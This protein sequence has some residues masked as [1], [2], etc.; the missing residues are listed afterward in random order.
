MAGIALSGL[1][2]GLNTEAIITKLMEVERAPKARLETREGQVKARG[3]MLGEIQ[4]KLQSLSDAAGALR[5]VGV[6]SEVQSVQSSDSTSVSAK[7]LSGTGPGGYQIEVTQLA[8]AEQRTFAF[9]AGEAASQLTINGAT[10]ELGASA[11]LEEAAAAINGNAETDVYAVAS[12]GKLIL[13]SRTTGAANAIAAS[14]ATISEE[15]EKLKVGRDAEYS[16]D[17]VA[18]TSS[19]NVTTEAVPGLELSLKSLTSTP[20]TVTVG[21]PEPNHEEITSKLKAFVSAYNA[22]LDAIRSRVTETRVANPKSQA[23]SN[24]G[25][26]FG[27]SGLNDLLSQMRNF[28]SES[29]LSALGIGTGAPSKN[30]SSESGS[31]IGRLVLDESKLESALE[32]E[33]VAIQKLVGGFSESFEGLLTPTLEPSGTMATRLEAV[34]AE[35]RQLSES[36][37]TLD[38]RLEQREERLHMQFAELEAALSKSQSESQW[39]TSQIEGL[40]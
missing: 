23:E 28:V 6:W 37:T 2:S 13:S 31:V 16:V 25:V 35:T 19:S 24:R 30:V 38:A 5:S 17:G 40:P 1:A 14:G 3:Q 12:G 27:D 10:V 26:L 11:T 21:N 36:M 20:V 29:G 22:A 32:A 8:R 15:A 39:L 33:P 7:R 4:S 18:A 9:T 34:S